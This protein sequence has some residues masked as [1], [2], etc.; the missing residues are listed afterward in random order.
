MLLVGASGRVGQMVMHHWK[1][2]PR[3]IHITPQYR[4][5]GPAGSLVWDPLKMGS[6]AKDGMGNIRGYDAM[7]ILAGVISGSSQKLS[8]NTTLAEAC[9]SA[10]SRA[11]IARVLLASSSAVY[12]SSDGQA[13]SERS[14]CS[15]ANDYGV[16]KLK[17]EEACAQ[18]RETGID[19]CFLRIGN[20]AGAD[21]LLLNIDETGPAKPL[22]IDIFPNGY[23][24][25]RS[26][27]GAQTLTQ[28][29]QSLCFH[30]SPLPHILNVASPTPLSMASLADAARHPWRKRIASTK[31]NQN[32]TLDCSMLAD[33]HAFSESDS[34]PIE[35]IRQWKDTKRQ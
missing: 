13:F 17:M 26:Y 5:I 18:W 10:A 2:D 11:G 35:M 34:N 9:L 20:V 15:P 8:I 7:I 30:P 6:S 24:P 28:V 19:L 4:G 14:F 23:G 27:I 12:G 1:K 29:L 22:Q 32:V 31:S 16:A 21:A 3:E 33:L 25:V